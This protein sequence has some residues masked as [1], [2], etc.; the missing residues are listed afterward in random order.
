[1]PARAWGFKSPL[2]HQGTVT[3]RCAESGESAIG[4]PLSDPVPSS[5]SFVCPRRAAFDRSGTRSSRGLPFPRLKPL[6]CQTVRDIVMYIM[7]FIN[8][9]SMFGMVGTILMHSGKGG[10][11]SD[12][13]G[14]GSGA[15][16]GSAAAEK[17]LNRITFVIALVWIISILSLGFLLTK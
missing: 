6:G 17:N 16:L 11:L 12:M 14:G 8:V 5:P 9:V 2:R 1:M 13:F 3:N 15:G 10:G 4:L 7:V